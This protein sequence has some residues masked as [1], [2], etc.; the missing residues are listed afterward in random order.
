MELL[1]AI[2]ARRAVRE[3]TDAPLSKETIHELIDAAIQAPSA[4][5]QQP[6]SFAVLLDADRIE[7]Y[8]QNAKEWLLEN[9]LQQ[10]GEMTQTLQRADYS[11]FYHAPALV[12]ISAT[13]HTTQSAEDCCLAAQNLML[14][15][16]AHQLGTCWIGL[17]RP[18]LNLD[19][20]KVEL[21]IPQ[22][23]QVV[24]PIIVGHPSKWPDPHE[25]NPAEINWLAPMK[26]GA[27]MQFYGS[28]PGSRGST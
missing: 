6:W 1:H 22:R 7:G 27:Y 20:T 19:A 26:R 16:R 5:N 15:A 21:G 11:L 25:R 23:Y 12:L 24:A 3:Y 17:A 28:E 8:A 4:R 2:A 13:D 14:A 18:W 9:H 10:L